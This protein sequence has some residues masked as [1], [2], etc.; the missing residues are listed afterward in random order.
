MADKPFD[1]LGM[2]QQAFRCDGMTDVADGQTDAFWGE[3]TS[4]APVQK[5]LIGP[6]GFIGGTTQRK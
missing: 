3:A 2:A 6:Q 4:D 1:L 5:V